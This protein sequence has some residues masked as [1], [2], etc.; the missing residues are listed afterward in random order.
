MKEKNETFMI[1]ADYEEYFPE[2]YKGVYLYSN[3]KELFRSNIGKIKKDY[4]N[5]LDWAR[6]NVSGTIYNSST[7]DNYF[8]DIH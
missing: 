2:T 5:V 8:M 3:G 1:V 7:I 6:K 4:T